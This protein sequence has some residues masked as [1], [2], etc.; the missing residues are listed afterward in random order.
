MR[1]KGVKKRK[2][3]KKKRERLSKGKENKRGGMGREEKK[4]NTCLSLATLALA[5]PLH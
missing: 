3:K 1:E 5:L 2:I 4:T